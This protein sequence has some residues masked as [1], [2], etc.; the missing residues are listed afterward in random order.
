MKL[1]YEKINAFFRKWKREIMRNSR[2]ITALTILGLV[3]GCVLFILETAKNTGKSMEFSPR[4]KFFYDFSQ[5]GVKDFINYLAFSLDYFYFWINK[6]SVF[7][8][9]I[10]ILLISRG[11]QG[12]I[13]FSGK[14]NKRVDRELK[15]L[16]WNW[17]YRRQ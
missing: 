7:C 16:I 6:Y 15:R 5:M 13:W 1:F 12:W 11:N 8:S 10:F 4:G 9:Y 17:S 14:N 2:L 3:G